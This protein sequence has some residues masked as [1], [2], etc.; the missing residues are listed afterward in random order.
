MPIYEM[1]SDEIRRVP[2]TTFA[3]EHILERQHLQRLLRSSIEMVAR[4]AM[5]LAEEFGDWEDS[6][7]R[8]DLL[9]LDKEG[10]LV[11]VELKRDHDGGHME[12]QALRYAAMVSTMTFTDAVDAHQRYLKGLGREDDA[13]AAILQHLEWDEPH[14]DV[15]AQ[16]VRIVL[17]SADFSSEITSTVLWLNER[18]LDIR[19]VRVEPYKLDNRILLD[20]QPIIPLPE[21]ADYQVKVKAK[22]TESRTSKTAGKGRDYTQYDLY[23]SG[24]HHGAPPMRHMIFQVVRAVIAHGAKRADLPDLARRWLVADGHASTREEFVA[25]VRTQLA[26]PV[27]ERRWFLNDDE[28]FRDDTSTFALSNQWTGP[29]VLSIISQIAKQYPELDI[30]CEASSS[31]G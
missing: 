31:I 18:G 6:S 28:L 22:T 8:I 1:S 23:I 24:T 15:F 25:L 11:V 13:R 30:R 3:K 4:G 17:V 21:A 14:E 7:R 29:D 19:C 26:K 27:D 9:A 10:N 12:L 20:I 2:T 5:V 16:D